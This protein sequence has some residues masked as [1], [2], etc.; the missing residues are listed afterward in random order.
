MR[1]LLLAVLLMSA[2]AM[3]QDVIIENR[4]VLTMPVGLHCQTIG[5]RTYCNDYGSSSFGGSFSCQ[6]IGNQTYCN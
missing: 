5:S 4:E 3:A 1:K 2:S 6:R